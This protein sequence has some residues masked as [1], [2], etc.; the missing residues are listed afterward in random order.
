M[1]TQKQKFNMYSP[2]FQDTGLKHHSYVNDS[3][4]QVLR[5]S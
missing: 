4:G 1:I 5:E 3:Q 2:K